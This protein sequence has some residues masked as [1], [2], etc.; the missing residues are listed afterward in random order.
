MALRLSCRV[1]S[2][3]VMSMAGES[4]GDGLGGRVPA[5]C[6]FSLTLVPLLSIVV[7]EVL[8][9]LLLC[10]LQD[11]L[12]EIRRHPHTRVHPDCAD[13]MLVLEMK[14][15]VK[16]RGNGLGFLFLAT[17]ISRDDARESCA[18]RSPSPSAKPRLGPLFGEEDSEQSA[19]RD[20]E[21][22]HRDAQQQTPPSL[23]LA[24]I[25]ESRGDRSSIVHGY[26]NGTGD[27]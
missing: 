17:L 5:E 16:L 20:L 26:R 11:Y 22:Q 10:C 14:A 27:L 15:R 25:S 21:S 19:G 9:L 2:C 3:H 4:V 24:R 1:V 7:Q 13:G 23:S 8:A 12:G 18:T 6:Q